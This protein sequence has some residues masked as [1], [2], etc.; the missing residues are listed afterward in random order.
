MKGIIVPFLLVLIIGSAVVPLPSA[1]LDGLIISNILLALFLL[2][3]SFS[4]SDPTHF[5][6]LPAILLL[7]VVSRLLVTISTTRAILTTGDAGAIVAAFGSI[8]VNDDLLVGCILFIIISIIQFLVVSKGSERVAEVSARFALDALPGR[9]MSLDADLRAGLLD[10]LSAQ[11]RRQDLQVESRLYGAL[12]GAMKFIKGDTIATICVTIINMVGGIISG[13]LRDGKPIIEALNTYTVL[14]IGDGLAGQIPSLITCVAAGV[15]VTRV[16]RGDDKSAEA[17]ILSQL[18]SMPKARLITAVSAI[19]LSFV[20]GMPTLTCL[21]IGLP[22]GL[23]TLWS[24]TKKSPSDLIPATFSPAPLAP[25]GVIVSAD[26]LSSSLPAVSII[27]LLEKVRQ[28]TFDKWGIILP[29][30]SLSMVSAPPDKRT[31]LRAEIQG[32]TVIAYSPEAEELEPLEVFIRQLEGIVQSE[33]P[34]LLNDAMTRSLLDLHNSHQGELIATLIPGQITV[35]QVTQLLRDL[36]S[37]G[38]SVRSFDRLLQVVSEKVPLVGTGRPLLEETRIALRR[39]IMQPFILSSEKRLFG[40]VSAAIDGALMH[41][42]RSGGIPPLTLIQEITAW[43]AARR[44]LL[45]G[46]VVGRA[47]RAILRDILRH[48]GIEMAVYAREE[49]IGF[50]YEIRELLTLVEDEPADDSSDLAN[51]ATSSFEQMTTAWQ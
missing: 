26:R 16:P 20:P 3:G 39:A 33:L 15:L 14:S 5:S 38:V 32:T 23:S 24:S 35:S 40:S 44:D 22:L 36:L 50:S 19:L 13:T 51:N 37:E 47:S 7:G 30:F 29:V 43:I 2:I 6:T 17:D 12:D 8:M 18:G 48:N 1:M 21:V 34:A 27:E 42:E 10:P 31:E 46:I 45:H 9:Q 4:V 11:Q 25:I 49:L 28:S 41:A